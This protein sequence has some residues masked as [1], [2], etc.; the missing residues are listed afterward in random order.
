MP[1]SMSIDAFEAHM[2]IIPI[3]IRRDVVVKIHGIPYDLTREEAERLILIIKAHVMQ[4]APAPEGE[5]D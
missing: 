4:S 5:Q 3:Q 1:R 2:G